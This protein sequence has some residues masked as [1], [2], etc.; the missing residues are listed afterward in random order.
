[1]RGLRPLSPPFAIVRV[2]LVLYACSFVPTVAVARGAPCDPQ[3]ITGNLTI[4][5]TD[6]QYDDTDLVVR[7]ATVTIVGSHRFCRLTLEQG[8]V[9]TS[10]AGES[11]GVAV[12]V[13]G[14]MVID[15][16]RRVDGSGKGWPSRGGP[17]TA[18]VGTNGG[19]GH[20]GRGGDDDAQLL[21][22]TQVLGGRIVACELSPSAFSSWR[23]SFVGAPVP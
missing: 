14:S 22:R 4:G 6:L 3:V 16:T 1:M 2:A 12:E 13:L 21:L 23:S 18:M 8:A 19:G 9:L 7:G 10:V 20:G 11:T 17:G 5:A 15:A